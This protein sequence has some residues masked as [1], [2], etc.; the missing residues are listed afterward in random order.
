MN[1]AYRI[2]ATHMER[3]KRGFD[4]E[5]QAL[6]V[7]TTIEMFGLVGCSVGLVVCIW[8]ELYLSSIACFTISYEKTRLS[9]RLNAER[10]MVMCVAFT[11]NVCARLCLCSSGR[12]NLIRCLLL[13]R[14]RLQNCRRYV[15][16]FR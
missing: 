2:E 16:V 12:F 15:L 3:G 4:I 9:R 11:S 10:K 6:L 5:Y 7:R 13:V 8:L 1:T 14:I